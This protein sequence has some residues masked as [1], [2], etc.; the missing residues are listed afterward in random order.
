MFIS[1]QG[2][3]ISAGDEG[4]DEHL[5]SDPTALKLLVVKGTKNKA[6]FP[7][8]VLRKGIDEK[9]FS[10]DTVMEGVLWLGYSKILFKSYNEPAI[11]K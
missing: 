7:H 9:T 10:V 2:A 11:V 6:V 1:R 5:W 4:W 8:A 3:I